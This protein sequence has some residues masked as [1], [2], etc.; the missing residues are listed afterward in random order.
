MIYSSFRA[1]FT[2]FTFVVKEAFRAVILYYVVLKV[3]Q[4]YI[5]NTF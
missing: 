4:H 1:L 3:Q 2:L 5:T